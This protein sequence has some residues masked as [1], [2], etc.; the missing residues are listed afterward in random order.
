MRT[1]R[2]KSLAVLLA[3]AMA[4]VTFSMPDDIQAAKKKSVTLSKKTVQVREKK[5]KR[6]KV[7]NSTGK[8]I[9]SVKWKVIKGSSVIKLSKKSKSGVTIKG[10]KKGT[11]TVR[12][13]IKAGSKT[14]TSKVK[15]SVTKP[16]TKKTLKLSTEKISLKTGSSQKITI[17]NTTGLAVKSVKW[18]VTKGGDVVTLS[19]KSKKAVTVKAS[20]TGAA[21]LQAKIKTADGTATRTA[22]IT[23]TAGTSTVQSTEILHYNMTCSAD[24]AYLT[25]QSGKGNHGELVG[26]NPQIQENQSLLLDNGG[27]IKLPEKAFAGKDTLTISIWLRNYSYKK[28]TSA[29]FVG[30]KED[31]PGPSA[32]WLLNPSNLDGRMKSVVTN[33][34]N[35]AAPWTTE[36]GLSPTEAA[37]GVNAPITEAGW[38]H[39]VTVIKPGSITGYLNGAKAG[40]VK[41]T[42]K[43]SDFGNDIVAYIGK[44]SYKDPTWMGFVREVQ[45]WQEAKTDAQV[46][47]LYNDTKVKNVKAKGTKSDVFIKDR[48]DPYITRGVGEDG[49]QYYYFTA[50]FP[51]YSENDADGYDRVVLRRSET[52]NGLKDAEEKVI[53]K[54]T[55]S[56]QSHRF[57]WAPEMHYIGGKWYMYYAGSS[58]TTDRWLINCC[59]LRCTGQD[60]YNDSWE[61]MGKFQAASGD[62]FSFTRF[63]LDMTY[64]ECNGKH[65]VIWAQ[66]GPA[67]NL[68]MAQINPDEPWKTI[69]NPVC[70]T[71]PEYYWECATF[72]VNEGPSVVQHNG[73]VIVAYSASGTGPEYCIGYLYADASADLMDINSWTKQTTPT[74]TSEDLVDEYGPGHNSFTKDEDGNDI[75]VYHSRGRDCYE[76]KCGRARGDQ[77]PLYDPC[78]SARIRKIGWGENGLPILNQ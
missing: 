20:K 78:R 60:P 7:K 36:A 69:T 18:S 75:F 55:A 42:K 64:F 6:I 61:E 17:K 44:S 65:Y 63:S 32:Y 40:T 58:S 3:V 5:S 49:K 16:V 9:R 51:M 23:V 71:R 52:L 74:L 19:G 72:A 14:Y 27:Y 54:P 45:V 68:Y 8:K 24:G 38:N 34:T 10:R 77:D 37:N 67:S 53:F 35:A 12:A 47:K 4:A 57:I 25:D 46:T 73:K 21:I 13:K 26:V 33:T 43:L 22:G 76:N 31:D 50:S 48:A 70:L 15:V 1:N 66:Q 39:Y 59:V 29:M 11:A 2:Q 62:T 28:N 41:L 30:T 56:N